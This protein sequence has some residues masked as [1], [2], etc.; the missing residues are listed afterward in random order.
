MEILGD[1]GKLVLTVLLLVGW[2][3]LWRYILPRLGIST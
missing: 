3:V 1:I 2:Y